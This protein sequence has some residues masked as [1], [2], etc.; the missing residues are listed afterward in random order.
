MAISETN[1]HMQLVALTQQ[2]S[3]THILINAHF[4]LII[5]IWNTTH[6]QIPDGLTGGSRISRTGDF[7]LQITMASHST[8]Q[9]LIPV[10]YSPYSNQTNCCMYAAVVI[11]HSC[12]NYANL[13]VYDT[14]TDAWDLTFDNHISC[15]GENVHQIHGLPFFM[16]FTKFTMSKIK[17]QSNTLTTT[18]N[19]CYD[20]GQKILEMEYN[21]ILLQIKTCST[22]YDWSHTLFPENPINSSNFSILAGICEIIWNQHTRT[23]HHVY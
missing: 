15:H 20:I 8:T 17:F 1:T 11:I 3:Q 19:K 5:T 14:D 23:S 4:S 7:H 6:W 16:C 2:S 10:S 18:I 9:N 13:P 22:I 21:Q 12:L